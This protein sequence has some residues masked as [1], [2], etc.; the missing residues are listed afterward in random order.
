[1]NGQLHDFFSERL[2]IVDLL[3]RQGNLS[4]MNTFSTDLPR[5]FIVAAASHFEK[6]VSGQIMDF[7]SDAAGGQSQVL[8]FMSRKA[9]HRNYHSLFG[10]N[11]K[12]P[13]VFFAF[14][15]AACLSH[16]KE[17]VKSHEWLTTSAHDF[18]KLGE[19]RNQLVHRDFATHSPVY[20]ALEVREKFLSA[21]KFV[22][23]I[24]QILRL[25]EIEMDVHA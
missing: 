6:V 22:A 3:A 23:V 8:E 21:E 20:T 12:V 17:Q 13:N 1:M 15:G 9:M 24:P 16:Y 18:L 5:V 4:L 14:F 2:E 10:W 19:A 25:Q 11:D 7:V